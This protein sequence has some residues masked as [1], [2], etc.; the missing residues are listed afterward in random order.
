L[1]NPEYDRL[2]VKEWAKNNPEKIKQKNTAQSEKNA[3]AIAYARSHGIS[4]TWKTHTICRQ[5][6]RSHGLPV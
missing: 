3:Y 1:K 4:V 6:A 5:Y 2:K